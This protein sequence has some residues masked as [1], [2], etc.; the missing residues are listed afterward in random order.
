M[1]SLL[2]GGGRGSDLLA[3][4][5]ALADDLPSVMDDELLDLRTPGISFDTV[6]CFCFS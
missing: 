1:I 4:K 2:L 5:G 3:M 6:D